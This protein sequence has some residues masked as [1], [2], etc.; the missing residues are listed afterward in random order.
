[1]F[2]RT[3]SEAMLPTNVPDTDAAK[4]AH[5]VTIKHNNMILATFCSE[6]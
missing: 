4:F 5:P 6:L 2:L 3:L 1:M